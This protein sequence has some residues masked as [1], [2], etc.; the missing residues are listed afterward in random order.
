MDI[1]C[2]ENWD[3]DDDDYDSDYD[4]DL[5]EIEEE[6]TAIDWFE[7]DIPANYREFADTS[8]QSGPSSG[9]KKTNEP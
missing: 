1:A 5:E 4:D 9:A 2:K 3:D 7:D 6:D 8:V